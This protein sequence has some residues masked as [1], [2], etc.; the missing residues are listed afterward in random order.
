MSR[1]RLRFRLLL[2]LMGI[3]LI[4]TAG[5]S[6][7][8]KAKAKWPK[9]RS[10]DA[11]VRGQEVIWIDNEAYVK[12]PSANESKKCL[13]IP[14]EEFI[15]N[16]KAYAVT[17]KPTAI[18]EK[19]EWK[20]VETEAAPTAV[21]TSQKDAPS[22]VPEIPSPFKKR[23]MVVPFTDVT[24][25]GYEGLPDMVTQS[26]V[27]EIQAKSDRIVLFDANVMSEA[28]KERQIG[29]ESLDSPEV[30]R[31]AGQWFNIHAI[32]AGSIDHLFVSSA[33]SNITGKGKT[34]YA[35]AKIRAHLIDTET[36]R[37]QRSWEEKNP[38]FESKEKGDFPEEKAELKAIDLITSR[39]G[40]DAVRELEKIDWFATI[41]RVD[42]QRVYISAGKISG[43]Q[44]GDRLSVYPSDSPQDARG[45]VR[46]LNLFGLDA[47]V[48]EIVQ[49]QAIRVNDVVKPAL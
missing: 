16:P 48:A 27:S 28:L 43:V 7:L 19:E 31:L 47:S 22:R 4:A 40:Q 18:P 13:Y 29:F 15:A 45:Q 11:R 36:G 26:L 41:A 35:I 20:P 2:T 10:A 1:P 39:I 46:I 5:C 17:A 23:V 38:I 21:S 33:A 30:A 6:I 8:E 49:G 25:T 44:V 34:S 3:A 9:S 42:G 32:L 12:V 14:V 37:V 24:E